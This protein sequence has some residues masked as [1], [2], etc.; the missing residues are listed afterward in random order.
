MPFM[1]IVDNKGGVKEVESMTKN[2]YL[3]IRPQ[4]HPEQT[5]KNDF[6]KDNLP[7]QIHTTIEIGEECKKAKA[8]DETVFIHRTSI[9][10]FPRRIICSVKIADVTELNRKTAL[11][12]FSGHK[13]LNKTPPKKLQP[14]ASFYYA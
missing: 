1:F 4:E 14:G 13:A 8:N 9:K 3:V 2:L 6:N 10:G 7:V 12:K 5:F 11:V